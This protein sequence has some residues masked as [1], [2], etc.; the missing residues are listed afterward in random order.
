MVEA[1]ALAS[2]DRSAT[3]G[4]ILHTIRC[5]GRGEALLTPAL[6]GAMVARLGELRRLVDAWMPNLAGIDILSRR[7]REVLYL[8]SQ[9][10]SNQD[11]AHQ[12][13]IEVGTVKN[14]VHNILGKLKVGNRQEAASY[15]FLQQEKP[16]FA[17]RA[18][19]G[20]EAFR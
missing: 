17:L 20:Q 9:D 18:V 19:K 15:Y 7:E 5:V 8:I 14:H 12:L 3:V 1:G 4:E 13:T 11:I 16:Y 2:I 6:A 10:F